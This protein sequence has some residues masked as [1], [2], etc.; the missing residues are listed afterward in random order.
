MHTRKLILSGLTAAAL[1]L[2]ISLLQA[3]DRHRAAVTQ[4]DAQLPQALPKRVAQTVP[5]A[6]PSA[7]PDTS[8]VIGEIVAVDEDQ[9][10]VAD[11]KGASTTVEVRDDT[12]ITVDGKM[13]TADDLKAGQRVV[14]SMEDRDGAKIAIS[15]SARTKMM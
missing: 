3:S 13:G 2:P 8:I 4:D 9:L 11:S 7:Q 1:A 15:I 12:S 14:V 10:T 6:A 5:I